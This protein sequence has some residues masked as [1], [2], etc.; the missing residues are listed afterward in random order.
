MNNFR[1]KKINTLYLDHTAKWSGGEIAL[2]RSLTAINKNIIEPNMLLAEDGELIAKMQSIAIKT[3][4]L[5]LSKKSSEI[6][7]DNL[8]RN[9]VSNIDSFI[10][11]IQYSIL[12]SKWIRNSKINLIHCNSLK[13]D[14]YGGI[15]GRISKIPTIWHIRDH[16]DEPYLPRKI[17]SIFRTLARSLP[18]GIISNSESTLK[19]LQ[20]GKGKSKSRVIYDGLTKEELNS[21]P[22]D[23]FISWRRKLPKIGLLGRIVEWKG[24]HIFLNAII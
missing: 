8:D 12:L 24:Q 15:A 1:S 2:F 22:P 18:L 5:P 11:Y 3:T 20:Y 14:L 23:Q 4:V 13:S 21:P 16:I 6:R 7:K 17:V 19:S 9:L 10:E